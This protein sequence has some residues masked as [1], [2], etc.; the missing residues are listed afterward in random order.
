M[1]NP[2]NNPLTSTWTLPSYSFLGQPG[3]IASL[4]WDAN[5]IEAAPE[6]HGSTR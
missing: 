1:D 3:A 2:S 5:V 4:L 6:Y